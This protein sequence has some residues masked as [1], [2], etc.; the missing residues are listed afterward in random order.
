MDYGHVYMLQSVYLDLFLWFYI[1]AHGPECLSKSIALV[2]AGHGPEGLLS[3]F[4]FLPPQLSP[5]LF[6]GPN[7][8]TAQQEVG[9]PG[10]CAGWY[11]LLSISQSLGSDFVISPRR[12]MSAALLFQTTRHL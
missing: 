7:V 1:I 4:L 2:F 5:H 10:P 3:E 9:F 12:S 6:F 8:S 11:G